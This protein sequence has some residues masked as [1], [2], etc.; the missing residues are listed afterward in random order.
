MKNLPEKINFCNIQTYDVIFF[1][2]D[3]IIIK[4]A[5]FLKVVS[6]SRP[7]GLYHSSDDFFESAWKLEKIEFKIFDLK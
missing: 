1:D 7:I 6:E 4:M 3:V 5:E 2:Y